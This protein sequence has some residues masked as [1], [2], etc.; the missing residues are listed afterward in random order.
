MLFKIRD[1]RH[2][3]AIEVGVGG[4]L[5][6]VVVDNEQTSK[7]LIDK[8]TFGFTT[9]IPNEKVVSKPIAREIRE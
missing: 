1:K 5:Q 4:R 6:N 9:F 2:E 7:L 3:R 8:N